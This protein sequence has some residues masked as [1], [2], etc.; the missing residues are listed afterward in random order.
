MGLFPVG[1][2]LSAVTVFVQPMLKLSSSWRDFTGVLL[3]ALGDVLLQQT[4]LSSG[5]Y[6]LSVP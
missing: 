6:T 4:L 5:S 3:T 2:K 1:I